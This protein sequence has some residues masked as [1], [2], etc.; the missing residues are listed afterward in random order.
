MGA[1]LRR[2]AELNPDR[3]AL[4][5]TDSRWTYA[6]QD[7]FEF[8]FPWRCPG[9][10]GT[11][12]ASGTVV[13]ALASVTDDHLMFI[14]QERITFT[15]L[16]ASLAQLCRMLPELGIGRLQTARLVSDRLLTSDGRTGQSR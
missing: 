14:E 13:L 6:Q 2:T 7:A 16:V 8:D 1:L 9:V 5:A 12:A 4:V 11:F 3:V 15:S 10:L